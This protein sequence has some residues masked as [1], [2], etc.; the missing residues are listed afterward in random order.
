MTVDSPSGRQVLFWCILDFGKGS[1][2]FEIY[3]NLGGVGGTIVLGRGTVSSDL[4]NRLGILDSRKEIF[5]GLADESMEEAL[6]HEVIRQFSLNKPHHGIAFSMPVKYAFAKHGGLETVASGKKKEGVNGLDYEAI[7]VVVGKD[8]KDEVLEAAKSAGAT[9]GT[10]IHGRGVASK[11]KQTLFN[12]HIE[13]E[14]DIILIV[15]S[16]DKSHAIVDAIK[17]RL[18]IDRPGAGIIF[19]TDITR[20][21]GLRRD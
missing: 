16:R 18:D 14:K 5:L 11:E 6:Y 15:S 3:R 12:I 4:M 20:A 8:Q 9:G 17:H 2:M 13:P 21:E 1:K 19:V 7:F 10:I